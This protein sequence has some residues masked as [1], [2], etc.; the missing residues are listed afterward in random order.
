METL[1]R[2]LE[3]RV[4]ERT[5]QVRAGARREAQEREKFYQVLDQSQYPVCLLRGPEHRYEYAN[6]AYEQLFPGRELVGYLVAEALPE[7]VP[8]GFITRLDRVYRTGE[9]FSGIETQVRHRP[10]S[11]QSPTLHR[12]LEGHVSPTP[13]TQCVTSVIKKLNA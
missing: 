7:T 10:F 1:N 13:T 12:R 11:S 8:Q 2:E 9:T 6:P 4:A 5:A 3:I